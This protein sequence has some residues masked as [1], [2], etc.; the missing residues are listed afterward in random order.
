MKRR[1]WLM[2]FRKEKG[3]SIKAIAKLSG[4]TQQCW[5]NYEIGKRTPRPNKAQKIAKL[6]GFKWTKFYEDEKE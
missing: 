5:S 3:L 1:E 2:Q 6:L 4:V